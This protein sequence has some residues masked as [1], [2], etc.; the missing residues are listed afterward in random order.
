MRARCQLRAYRQFQ[1]GGNSFRCGVQL[2]EHDF[3]ATEA[4]KL[5][6]PSDS[7]R[8]GK[9]GMQAKH[10]THTRQHKPRVHAYAHLAQRRSNILV[11]DPLY[12][13]PNSLVLAMVCAYLDMTAKNLVAL[14]H[15]P[16]GWSDAVV[17]A[18]ERQGLDIFLIAPGKANN[19]KIVLFAKATTGKKAHKH[20]TCFTRTS[21]EE[22]HIC[23]GLE[24]SSCFSDD[25][26]VNIFKNAQEIFRAAV[27]PTIVLTEDAG[28]A[29]TPKDGRA[30]KTGAASEPSFPMPTRKPPKIFEVGQKVLVQ[31]YGEMHPATV[32]E[33]MHNG[34]I[35][36]LWEAEDSHSY[37]TK[38]QLE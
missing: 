7:G 17:K 11:P 24:K 34:Q 19:T 38:E 28:A 14:V 10:V 27:E 4:K 25:E 31:W 3:L 6:Q 9:L 1:V 8:D 35:D 2:V 5:T 26:C 32:R 15:N 30:E 16:A 23:I 21:I 18:V 20:L 33:V 37:V 29:A 13:N 12:Q 36:V 22:R